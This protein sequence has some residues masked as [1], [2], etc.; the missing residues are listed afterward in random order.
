MIIK[1]IKIAPEIAIKIFEKH[2]IFIEEI[3]DVL[4]DDHP[5]Y[6]RIA[7]K[8]Y[9]AIG[10]SRSRYIL[11]IFRY[12]NKEAGIQT[13]YEASRRQIRSYKRYVRR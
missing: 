8:Q 10:I 11:I 13:A 9:L 1:A 6:K 12:E 4:K 2:N 7:G 3:K 5:V